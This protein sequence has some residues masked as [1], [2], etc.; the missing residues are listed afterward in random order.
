MGVRSCI[1]VGAVNYMIISSPIKMC[2]LSFI[3]SPEHVVVDIVDG[4]DDD[5]NVDGVE[6]G[7]RF[8]IVK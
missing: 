3:Y 7:E 4:A 5:D 2:F 1:D 6:C 8:D